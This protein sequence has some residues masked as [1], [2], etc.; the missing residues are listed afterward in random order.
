MKRNLWRH[1]LLTST[2]LVALTIAASLPVSVAGA[3]S[4]RPTAPR[5]VRASAQ[6]DAAHV[7]WSV[8]ASSGGSAVTRYVVTSHP[9]SRWCATASRS[10][11]VKGLTGGLSYTFTVVAKNASGAGPSSSSSNK[12]TI[13]LS[14][15]AA[16]ADFLAAVTAF[17]TSF[18]AAD[19]A[20]VA[21]PTNATQAQVTAAVDSLQATYTSYASTLS[22]VK[23]PSVA[24]ADVSALATEV[25]TLGTDEV[26]FFNSATL[27]DEALSLVSL[28]SDSNKEIVVDSKV[29]TDLSLTQLISGPVA[30]TSTPVAFGTAQTVHDFFG[31]TASI[32]VTQVVDP[33]T[34][35]TGSGLPDPGYR[36]VAVEASVSN[37]TG[38]V[39]GDANLAMTVTGSDGVTY[40]ADFG[41]ASQCTNFTLGEFQV[42][43]GDTATGCV[44]FQLPSAITVK[45]VQF[46]LGAGYLDT[47]AWT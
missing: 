2:A 39:D 20:I 4:S 36:F 24:Q 16:G 26:A 21:L 8:P 30:S 9:L 22:R 38:Q 27:S 1:G 35:G 17:A 6:T 3:S 29:R 37:T 19:A 11:V 18:S 46:T 43:T 32:T 45:S 10:C 44:L 42:P 47:V 34:A 33:A 14:I 41:T 31:D 12:V 28:Q 23:W 40:S 7:S 15:K 13:A 5:S 25:T